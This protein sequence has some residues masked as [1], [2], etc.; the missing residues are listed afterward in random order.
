MGCDP[1]VAKPLF[2]LWFNYCI[3]GARPHA[4]I[5]GVSCQPLTDAQNLAVMLCALF[6]YGKYL[7]L[8]RALD[9]LLT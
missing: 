3:N 7:S 1:D 2:G 6:I 4:G 9:T 5:E 8:I